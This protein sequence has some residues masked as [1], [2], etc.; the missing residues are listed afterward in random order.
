[1][2]PGVTG[3]GEAG[4]GRGD[5]QG[6]P[7]Q[8]LWSQLGN[9]SPTTLSILFSKTTS[10]SIM[11]QSSSANRIITIL[12]PPPHP[13]TL[14]RRQRNNVD[15][16]LCLSISAI[17]AISFF[18]S[19]SPPTLSFFYFSF[20]PFLFYARTIFIKTTFVSLSLHRAIYYQPAH[21][22]DN[23]QVLAS[24]CCDI[25]YNDLDLIFT[26]DLPTQKHYERVSSEE[27][28]Q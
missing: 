25:S 24:E 22:D 11:E 6:D 28:Q 7:A 4:A 14:L 21:D 8:W 9:N 17:V 26:V 2:R 3:E 16:L 23:F 13:T 1:M 10:P 15:W 12:I 5:R 27:K 20:Q 18:V 19:V